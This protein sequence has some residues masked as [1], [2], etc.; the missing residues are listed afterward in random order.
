M[1]KRFRV[2][3]IVCI[4]TI[5][6]GCQDSTPPSS[7]SL[8]EA[9]SLILDSNNSKYKLAIKQSITKIE[10]NEE[11]LESRIGITSHH[12]PVASEFVGEF[13]NE[14]LGVRNEEIKTI[15][16]IGPDHPEKCEGRFTSGVVAYKTNF[17]LLESNKSLVGELLKSDLINEEPSCME[18]E[19]SIGVQADYISYLVP[20]AQIVPITV[21]SSATVE[22]TNQVAGILSRFYDE[23]LFIVSVDFNHYR[24]EAQAQVYDQ[25]T[26]DA[27]ESMSVNDL[28]IDN[29]DSPPSLRVGVELARLNEAKPRIFG[30]TNS[31]E[32]TGHHAN[33]TS[34]FNVLFEKDL[35]K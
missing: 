2:L 6:V 33:T 29:V 24:T 8:E 9:E 31:Y 11:A 21:S 30:Y 7:V 5:L 16:V 35:V 14:F 28:T 32:Y 1:K 34:Y 12:L 26:I 4:S 19:H 20:E 18:K 10:R 22:E 3:A 27:I 25:E 15:V 13:Y 23:A 17:G